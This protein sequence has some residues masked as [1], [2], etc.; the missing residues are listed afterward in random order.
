MPERT[1]II[2]DTDIGGD[3]D[4]TWALIMMLGCPEL[5]VRLITASTGNVVLRAK[6]IAKLL[7]VAGRTDIPIGIGRREPEMEKNTCSQAEWVEDYDLADYGG[8]IYEDGSEAIVRTIGESAEPVTLVAIGPLPTVADALRLEP[9]ITSHSRFIGMHGSVYTGY[10]YDGSSEPCAESN[11]RFHTPDCQH[12]FS[13]DWDLTLT[14][15]DTCGRV[16]L[17]GELYRRLRDS[18]DPLIQ[19]L[20]LNNEIFA[21][22]ITWWP[23]YNPALHSTTLFDTVAVYLAFSEEL[24]RMERLNIVVTDDGFTKIDNAGKPITCAVEWHDLAAFHALLVE[25]LLNR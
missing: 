18:N 12:V 20:M 22:N 15:L 21:R 19:A 4:D 25:R 9:H 7:E 3:I 1:P 10:G 16:R 13:S 14:P 2:L 17:E 24:V 8:T 23:D 5:D 11:V 6:L